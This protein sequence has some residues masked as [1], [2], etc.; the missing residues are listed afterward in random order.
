MKVKAGRWLA[1]T[2]KERYA[3]LLLVRARQLHRERRKLTKDEYYQY[4]ES[5]ESLQ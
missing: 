3:I 2:K 1:F 5:L 4:H